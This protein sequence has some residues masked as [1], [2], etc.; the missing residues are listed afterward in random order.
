MR[1]AKT[2]DSLVHDVQATLYAA[3]VMHQTKS[4]HCDLQWTYFRTRKP[5]IAEA[6]KV[7]VSREDIL[8]RLER[9]VASAKEMQAIIEAGK[10]AKDLPKTLSHCDAFGGCPYRGICLAKDQPMQET[11][12]KSL[13]ASLKERKINPPEAAMAP[14]AVAAPAPTTITDRTGQTFDLP[15][16]KPKKGRPAKAEAAPIATPDEDLPIPSRA[17]IIGTLERQIMALVRTV[18][19]L[20]RS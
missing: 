5:Y 13:L 9:T 11:S 6:V 19:E 3:V 12:V 17:I 2:A 7:R 14:A 4:Q 1:W 16:E 15:T 10:T 20:V 18:F 8:P